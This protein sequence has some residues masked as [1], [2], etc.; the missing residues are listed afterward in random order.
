MHGAL[1]R[2][3]SANGQPAWNKLIVA[4]LVL[5]ALAAAWRF[6]PL[7]QLITPEHVSGWARVV[8]QAKWAPAALVLAY[9]P[10]EFIMF[11]RAALTLLGS[12][13][14]GPWRGFAYGFAG[15]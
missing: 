8:R 6:T 7:A 15:I 4:A 5:G 13:A 10:A 12:I 2:Q 1:R 14:F 3:R 9:T 11:P